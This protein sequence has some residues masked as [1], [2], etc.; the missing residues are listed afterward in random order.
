MSHTLGAILVI[1]LIAAAE[2]WLL[3]RAEAY[4]MHWSGEVAPASLS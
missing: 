3:A 4:L 1:A 2:L